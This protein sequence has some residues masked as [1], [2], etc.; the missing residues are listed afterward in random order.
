MRRRLR[1][2]IF[3]DTCAVPLSRSQAALD[4]R[5][6]RRAAL[7][8]QGSLTLT[9]NGTPRFTWD[10]GAWW[11]RVTMMEHWPGFLLT[12]VALLFGASFWWDVLRRLTGLGSGKST[13][14]M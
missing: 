8:A 12:F 4:A 5:Q 9:A 1:N 11:E 6:A 3:H 2:S 7:E 14:A 10:V 13:D